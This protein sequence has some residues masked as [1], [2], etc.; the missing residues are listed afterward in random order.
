MTDRNAYIMTQTTAAGER[1]SESE[2]EEPLKR[3][4]M[5]SSDDTDRFMMQDEGE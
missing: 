2:R 5:L 3:G 1:E 4:T